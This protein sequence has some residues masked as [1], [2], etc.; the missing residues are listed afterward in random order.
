[1]SDRGE[2][3]LSANGSEEDVSISEMIKLSSVWCLSGVC[4]SVKNSY[5][6]NV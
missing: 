5:V 1:M 4:L 3:Y 6:D 2:A